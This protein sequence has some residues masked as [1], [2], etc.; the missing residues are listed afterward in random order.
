MN[1]KSSV[2]Q[3]PKSVRWV[4]TSDMLAYFEN[5]E[6]TAT[7]ID[8]EGWLHT[9]DLG[10]MD[11][12]GYCRV[13]SRLKEMII[14]GGENVY[15]REIEDLLI[16]HPAI[17]AVAVVGLPD[18]DLGETVAAAIQ[19]HPGQDVPLQL[20]EEYCGER[21]AFYKVPRTWRVFDEFPQTGSGKVQKFAL[22]EKF[23]SPSE[24][25]AKR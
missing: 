16:A 12:Q 24:K 14:R 21:L 18:A 20:L 4:L 11:E 5:S 1:Q 25:G 8:E 19:F 6:A 17:A 9:G 22:R 23:M 3:T 2:A 13:V 10:S 15:P 7:T